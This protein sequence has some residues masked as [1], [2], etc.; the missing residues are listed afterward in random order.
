MADGATT[1]TK[2]CKPA[3]GVLGLPSLS[4]VFG[5]WASLCIITAT[6]VA[7]ML[8][9]PLFWMVL[10]A[11]AILMGDWLLW[12][13]LKFDGKPQRP[14]LRLLVN[15]LVCSLVLMWLAC[16]LIWLTIPAFRNAAMH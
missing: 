12:L 1:E 16:A 11:L 7:T 2:P 10:P 5:G 8:W 14:R 9:K 13:G 4:G 6:M 3:R 15:C